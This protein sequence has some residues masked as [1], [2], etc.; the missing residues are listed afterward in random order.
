MPKKHRNIVPDNIARLMSE[1]DRKL[2][3]IQTKEDAAKAGEAKLESELQKQCEAWL[4]RN[5]VAYLH[6]SPRAREK[7]GWPDLIF[8]Y[9]GRP[10]AIELKTA[11]G[12]L[13]EAQERML[14]Q[15][16]CNGWLVHVLRSYSAFIDIVMDI[17]TAGEQ[18][19]DNEYLE[20]LC[21]IWDLW[22]NCE[23][24]PNHSIEVDV[25][26]QQDD[27]LKSIGRILIEFEPEIL[28]AKKDDRMP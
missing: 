18:T 10:Y 28:E 5:N 22:E 6:L 13:S 17:E 2:L 19:M 3:G 12:R 4:M 9:R 25:A 21:R 24:Q 27:V 14:A 23:E 8:L 20:A 7:Q 26:C 15:M 11:T 16:R 1:S